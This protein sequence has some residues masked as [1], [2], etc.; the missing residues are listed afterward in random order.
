[1]DTVQSEDS[2]TQTK[3]A[4]P[5]R[6]QQAADEHVF[7]IGRPPLEEYLGF[8]TVQTMEGQAADHRVLADEWRSAN[9]H[10]R[11]LETEEAGLADKSPIGSA[12]PHLESLSAKVL[13]DP[14]FQRSF[15]IVPVTIGV[16]ELDRLVV[17]QKHINLAYVRSL[18]ESLGS[19]PSEET[20]FKMCLPFDHPQ[21]AVNS[22]RIANNAYVFV[23][24]SMDLRFLEPMFLGS[25][26]IAGYQPTGPV[27]GVIGLVVG[28]G[29]NFL[30]VIYAED[31]LVLNNGSHRAYALREMGLTQ[32]P[33]IIQYV[34]RREELKVIAGNDLQQNPELY[35]K[36]P[37]PPLLKDYFDPKL[38]KLVM[39]P[40]KLR[41]IKVTFGVE[42]IDV[43]AA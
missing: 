23:S 42:Q 31:R 25:H 34:S 13:A 4:S 18:K 15:N 20:I 12:L 2:S 29:S 10:I 19:A 30:N 35:L 8:L 11:E 33:C 14:I 1:M 7:L 16:V 37:R 38:R 40:R 17:F 22:T 28:F 24:P 9:D 36:A 5:T 21:P 39:V 43:P 3:A 32:A 6:Q 26:Q 27:S 41:Q